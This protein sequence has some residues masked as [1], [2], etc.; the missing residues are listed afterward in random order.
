MDLAALRQLVLGRSMLVVGLIAALAGAGLAAGIMVYGALVD[1]STYTMVSWALIAPLWSL[2]A[3]LWLL[4][5]RW[6]LAAAVPLGGLAVFAGMYYSDVYGQ[7]P[8]GL[9]FLLATAVVLLPN[10][11]KE[12]EPLR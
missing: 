11:A 5:R 6:L 4:V 1:G 12:G 8:A 9:L 7:F 10:Q 2:Q 3:L